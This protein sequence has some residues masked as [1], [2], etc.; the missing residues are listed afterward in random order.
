MIAWY[1]ICSACG[2]EVG[3]CCHITALLCH[4]RVEKTTMRTSTHPLS[5]SKLLTII[6][7]TMKIS[8]GEYN[9]DNDVNDFR[10]SIGTVN[11]SAD[12][13]LDL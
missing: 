12:T 1:C 6:D 4:L 7:D 10:G 2:P 8:D 11:N 3:M 9:S 13:E 5:A